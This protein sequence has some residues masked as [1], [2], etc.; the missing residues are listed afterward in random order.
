[1]V[2]LTLALNTIYNAGGIPCFEGVIEN[3][4]SDFKRPSAQSSVLLFIN[5]FTQ[6][7]G[8]LFV[9]SQNLHMTG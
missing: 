4:D 6:H 5:A 9:I 1:M 7:R 8:L 3:E 2:V